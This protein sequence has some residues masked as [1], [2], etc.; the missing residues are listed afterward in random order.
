MASTQKVTGTLR[1]AGY[2]PARTV[3]I[4]EE[5]R[6]Y[7]IITEGYRVFKIGGLVGVECCHCMS[8]KDAMAEALK[9]AG[10]T[11]TERGSS[12]ILAVA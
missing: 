9:S 7:N 5:D 10:L 2:K 4:Y 8:Q 1:K 12:G 6:S 11:V 3:R